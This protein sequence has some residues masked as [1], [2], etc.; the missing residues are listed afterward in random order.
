MSDDKF[1]DES[2][3]DAVA[4]E[5]SGCG[6]GC[7]CGQKDECGQGDEACGEGCGCG[8]EQEIQVNFFTYMTSLGYQAMIFLGE[9]P[10]P[11]TGQQEKNL[12]QAKFIID[13]LVMMK[14]KTKGNLNE[15]E[16]SFL[17][18]TLYELQMKFVEIAQ[19][20]GG[21]IIS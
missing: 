8:G 12:R 19:K 18:G 3:K 7:G 5:K 6:D 11:M 14:E 13:T 4:N 17:E 2:W 15:Q 16:N 1:V 20:D 21:S 10:N 9:I